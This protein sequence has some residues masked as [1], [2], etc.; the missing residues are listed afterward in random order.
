MAIRSE[1]NGGGKS[2]YIMKQ[3]RQLLLSTFDSSCPIRIAWI[4]LGLVT[5][6]IAGIG[7]TQKGHCELMVVCGLMR[8]NVRS[9]MKRHWR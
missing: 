3:A 8:I 4:L 9:V 6:Y 1:T 7:C 5:Q 2:Q